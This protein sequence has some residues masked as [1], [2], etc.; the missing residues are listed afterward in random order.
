VG[1]TL[2]AKKLPDGI[3]SHVC[4]LSVFPTVSTD[5]ASFKCAAMSSNLLVCSDQ[6]LMRDVWL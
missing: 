1:L 4:H 5:S 6:V 2:P 3:T